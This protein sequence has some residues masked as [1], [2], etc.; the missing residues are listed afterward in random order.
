MTSCHRGWQCGT[1][2]IY[3]LHTSHLEPYRTSVPYFISVFETY[4]T[5]TK[6]AYRT[7]VPYFL[8]KIEAYRTVPTYYTVL[9]FLLLTTRNFNWLWNHQPINQPSHSHIWRRLQLSFASAYKKPT[10]CAK[11]LGFLIQ[12]AYQSTVPVPFQT[13]RTVP[14]PLQK[15]R[16]VLLNKNWSVPYRT[17]VPYCHPCMSLLKTRKVILSE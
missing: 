7:S 4:R 5:F 17:Y 14:V 16:T 1:F 10:Q 9:P 2:R 11:S 8:A 15:R 12:T 3:V 13:R 6:K